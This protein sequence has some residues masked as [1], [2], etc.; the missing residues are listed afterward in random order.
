MM[1]M[2]LKTIKDREE[3]QCDITED[4]LH[5]IN[6]VNREMQ[7]NENT[8]VGSTD[9]KALY[10]SLEID[11]TIEKVC[12]LFL[13]DD[14]KVEGVDYKEVGLYLALTKTEDDLQESGVTD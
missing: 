12:E 3:G 9:V 6:K 10:P 8:I 5:E 1:S 14:V 2:L 13:E 7:L 4:M 11:F